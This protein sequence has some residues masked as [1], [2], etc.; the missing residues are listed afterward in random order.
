ML[1]TGIHEGILYMWSIS[2]K[3]DRLPFFCIR[4]IFFVQCIVT[5]KPKDAYFDFAYG[6]ANLNKL[7][8][9]RMKLS[10]LSPNFPVSADAVG[11]M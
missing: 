5:G 8:G 2:Q 7:H 3:D 1:T 6:L 9:T 11:P 4:L 10:P